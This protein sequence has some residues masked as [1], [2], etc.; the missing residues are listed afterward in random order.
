M[1]S[2]LVKRTVGVAIAIITLAFD[3]LNP[4]AAPRL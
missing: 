4:T 2:N 3:V 1:R